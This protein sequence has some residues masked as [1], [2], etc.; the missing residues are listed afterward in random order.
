MTLRCLAYTR[1]SKLRAHES[2]DT[3]LSLDAQEARMR[4]YCEAQ[5]WALAEVFRDARSR[6]DDPAGRVESIASGIRGGNSTTAAG[7]GSSG[8][9]EPKMVNQTI[10]LHGVVFGNGEDW[11]GFFRDKMMRHAFAGAGG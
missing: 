7:N 6:R 3:S 4:A 1:Q 11:D 2:A 8:Q 5:G 10:H 9:G